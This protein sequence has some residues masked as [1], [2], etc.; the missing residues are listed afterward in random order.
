MTLDRPCPWCGATEF[1]A[2]DPVR[3]EVSSPKKKGLGNTTKIAF[4]MVV[5]TGCEATQL[6]APKSVRASDF[7]H[8][9]VRVGG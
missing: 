4:T 6:F 9:V 5:C 1:A 3:I 7:E 8:T 2:I